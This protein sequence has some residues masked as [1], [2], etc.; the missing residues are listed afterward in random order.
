[1]AP[2]VHWLAPS[3]LWSEFTAY[4]D[5]TAFRSPAV[6]RFATDTFME[7]LQAMLANSP[8]DLRSTVAQPETWRTPNAGLPDPLS[9]PLQNVPAL[10]LKLFQPVH[11]RFYLVAASL[12]CRLPGLPDR[13]VKV[14]QGERTTFVM[15]RLQLKSTAA[16]PAGS[17]FDTNTYDETAW[18]TAGAVP[19]WVAADGSS[20]APGEEQNALFAFQFGAN[21]SRRRMFGGLIP[22]G[23]RQSFVTGRTLESQPGAPPVPA[24]P[25]DPRKIEFQRQVLDP[26]ADLAAWYNTLNPVY[27]NDDFAAAQGS[28]FILIDWANFLSTYLN[29]VW[30]AVQDASKA[31]NLTGAQLNLYNAL[32]ATVGDVN[33]SATRYP[34]TQAIPMALGFDT[35]FENQ[36]LTPGA[37]P[38]LPAGYPGP[39]LSDQ[40]DPALAALIGRPD[41]SQPLTQRPIQTLVEAALDQAGPAP[42]SAVPS[43]AKDPQNPQGDDWYMVRCVYERPQCAVNSKLPAVPLISLPSLPFQLASYFDPDAPARMITVALPVDTTPAALRKY[44]K[45]VAFMISDQLG[46]QMK[47]ITGLKDLMGGSV[48]D[49]GGFGLGMICSLSIPIITICAFIV[50]FIFLI[51]LNIIFFWLPFFKIC[52]PIPTFKAKG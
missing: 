33:H 26:W 42:V 27:P 44:P 52:F 17:P 5:K 32:S 22:V 1:M 41:D 43:P 46:Q 14:N 49:G 8:G 39:L 24:A 30:L 45:G 40:A 2:P 28:A 37:A 34:L 7:D 3:P 48:G 15:R 31:K 29:P 13:P 21:G 4:A 6:L 11:A 18:T 51:L 10:P 12:N 38:T 9:A 23:K 16:Q 36:V 50:L 19:G 35:A 25:D 47:R 20:L